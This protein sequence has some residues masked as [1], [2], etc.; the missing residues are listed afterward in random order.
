MS[1]GKRLTATGA[2]LK[3]FDLTGAGTWLVRLTI[4]DAINGAQAQAMAT[5]EVRDPAD[6]G[7][8]MTL[9][10]HADLLVAPT[11]SMIHYTSV[12]SGGIAP[13]EYRWDLS[14]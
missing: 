13:F 6:A 3:D 1:D 5:V 11:P 2:C 10:I 14:D 7:V 8:K 9:A 12:L 4:R